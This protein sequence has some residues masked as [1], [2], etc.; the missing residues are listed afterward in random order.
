[1][2]LPLLLHFP[3]S[4]IPNSLTHTVK[5]DEFFTE[6]KPGKEFHFLYPSI[7]SPLKA[8]ICHKKQVSNLLHQ[9]LQVKLLSQNS[10]LLGVWV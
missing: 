10:W 3:K 4:T 5:L 2:T 7:P 6:F 9:P 8:Q 1:M